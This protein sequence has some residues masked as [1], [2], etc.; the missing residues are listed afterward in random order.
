ADFVYTD[1]LGFKKLNDIIPQGSGW[2][3]RGQGVS[4]NASRQIVGSGSRAG[5]T[6]LRMFRMQLPKAHKASCEARAVCGGDDG[7]AIC[8]FSDGVVETSPGHFVAVFGYDNASSSSVHPSI[9][10]TRLVRPDG[11]VVATQQPAPPANLL[12]GT[13]IGGY[14]PVFD[15]G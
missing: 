14:L 6:G 8:L 4:I 10:E 7:D 9:N 15:S 12:P 1:Q 3:L 2:D 13:H 11:T 5:F